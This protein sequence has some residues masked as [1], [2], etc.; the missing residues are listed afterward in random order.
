MCKIIQCNPLNPKPPSHITNAGASLAFHVDATI[1]A[2]AAQHLATD[3]HINPA[4]L[5][6]HHFEELICSDFVLWGWRWMEE[7]VKPRDL[8]LC[9]CQG[10]F[11]FQFPF[12]ELKC[13]F[14][15]RARPGAALISTNIQT[16]VGLKSW[17]PQTPGAAQTCHSSTQH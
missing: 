3:P 15:S 8:Q 10:E 6:N 4:Y 9:C 5:P 12:P 14:P 16:P 17:T 2:P 11:Y 7:R 13:P 1:Q